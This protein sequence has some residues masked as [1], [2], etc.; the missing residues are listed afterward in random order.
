[1]LVTG[2]LQAA[3]AAGTTV[4]LPQPTLQMGTPPPRKTLQPAKLGANL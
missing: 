2:V 3:G 4:S 1:M